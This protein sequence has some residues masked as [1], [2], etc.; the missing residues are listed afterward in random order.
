MWIKE[1]KW[2][3]LRYTSLKCRQRMK[4]EIKICSSY[5]QT[6]IQNTAVCKWSKLYLSVPKKK[7]FK[8]MKIFMWLSILSWVRKNLLSMKVVV[9]K[10]R[11]EIIDCV[12]VVVKWHDDNVSSRYLDHHVS[13]PNNDLTTGYSTS[14]SATLPCLSCLLC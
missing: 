4:T 1:V 13:S 9:W 6:F 2:L 5:D 14:N 12:G 11:Q 7:M 8:N 3:E 10:R